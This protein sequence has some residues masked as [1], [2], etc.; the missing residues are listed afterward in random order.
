MSTSPRSPFVY[1]NA[2]APEV[3]HDLR[4]ARLRLAKIEVGAGRLMQGGKA[5]LDKGMTLLQELHRARPDSVEYHANRVRRGK[6][7]AANPTRMPI[8]C[9]LDYSD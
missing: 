4:L 6:C 8:E 5:L 2:N 3:R 1:D 9:L 7:R